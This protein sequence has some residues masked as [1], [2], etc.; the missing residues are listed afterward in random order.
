MVI[1]QKKRKLSGVTRMTEKSKFD[2]YLKLRMNKFTATEVNCRKS[3][4]IVR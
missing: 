3:R 4:K 1:I 2:I